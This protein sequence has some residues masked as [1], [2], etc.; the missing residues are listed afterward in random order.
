MAEFCRL[1]L[2]TVLLVAAFSA[3]F[4]VDAQARMCVYYARMLTDFDIR[5]NAWT[6][7]HQAAGR[8]DRGIRPDVGSVL[9]FRKTT[10]NPYGHVST[11]SRVIDRRTILVDHSWLRGRGLRRNMRVVDTS[12]RNDWSRVRVWYEPGNGL[13]VRHYPTY[14]FIHPRA[15]GHQ[16]SP[17]S[18][19]LQLASIP[20][21]RGR[22]W[23]QAGPIPPLD[24]AALPVHPSVKPAM[25]TMDDG[26]LVKQSVADDE[27]FAM[28]SF[29][30]APRGRGRPS[31]MS[32]AIAVVAAV[33]ERNVSANLSV[34]PTPKPV[35]VHRATNE[36][37]QA[38]SAANWVLP[39]RKPRHAR[40]DQPRPRTKPV[41][42]PAHVDGLVAQPSIDVPYRPGMQVAA[43]P[44]DVS[45]FGSE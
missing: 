33:S 40:L 42:S 41:P 25:T 30:A 11:V 37:I 29:T 17:S 44:F 9:V 10:H 19:L 4:I 6:W 35:E 36:P 38:L 22:P 15:P 26:T 20:V 16:A 31:V 8:Y 12:Q 43:A 32:E 34:R 24:V 7:W 23:V 18:A 28:V 21:P 13:G 39:E 5:G 3:L 14:G 2:R 45:Q 27:R 1:W